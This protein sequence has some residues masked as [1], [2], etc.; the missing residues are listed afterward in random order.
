MI[1]VVR[2]ARR[3]AMKARLQPGVRIDAI[4]RLNTA[5]RI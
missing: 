2:I 1:R 3:G 5:Q 4:V